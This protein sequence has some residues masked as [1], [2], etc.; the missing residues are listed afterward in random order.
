MNEQ[1]DVGQQ[2]ETRPERES[3]MSN[4]NKPNHDKTITIVVN[5][6]PKQVEDKRLSYEAVVNLAYDGNPPQGA[7]VVITVTY[8]RGDHPPQGTL[9]PGQEVKVKEGM[10]FNVTATDKS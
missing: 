10:I 6:R 1:N 4:E 3:A 7:N 9:A 8:S 2:A 5:G